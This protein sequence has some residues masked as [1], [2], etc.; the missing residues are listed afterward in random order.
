MRVPVNPSGCIVADLASIARRK[1]Y[2]GQVSG[3][4]LPKSLLQGFSILF[5]ST[6]IWIRSYRQINRL[7]QSHTPGR[8]P[9]QNKS[10]P[11]K[12]H[13]QMSMDVFDFP[14]DPDH[15]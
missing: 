10:K 4:F 12:R 14:S 11:Q 3:K 13:E 5:C 15:G 8:D 9:M 7:R 2:G 1:V 6:H